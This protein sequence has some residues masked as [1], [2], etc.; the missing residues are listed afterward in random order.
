[1]NHLAPTV[2]NAQLYSPAAAPAPAPDAQVIAHKFGGTSVAS[3]QRYRHVAELLLQR[4][5]PTQV[6]VVSAMKGV[7]DALIELATLAAHGQPR[8]RDA[9]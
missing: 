5:E 2:G 3:A 7:T 8:W 4:P 9:W 6:V 1:M